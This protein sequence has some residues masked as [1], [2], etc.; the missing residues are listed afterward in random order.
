MSRA[1]LRARLLRYLE[2]QGF[3]NKDPLEDKDQIRK[4]HRAAVL[5]QREKARKHLKRYEPR[6]LG[7]IA[8]G[9]DLDVEKIKPVLIPVSRRS[10]EERLFRYAR[11]HW[12]IPISSGYGRRLRFLVWDDHH[13][14]LMG[15]IGLSDPVYSLAPRDRWVGWDKD[16]KKRRL[17]NVMDAFVL[18]ATPPYSHVLGGKLVAL[19]VWSREVSRAFSE[20]YAQRRSTIRG[21]PVGQLALITTTSALGR[22]SLYNRLKFKGQTIFHPVGFTRGTG[23]LPFL[24][25]FY[26]E[27]FQLV[28][29]QAQPT[30][31]HLSWGKGYRNRRE[32][33][34][35][36]LKLL[37][38]P[39]DMR[40][41]GVKREVYV[42][43]LG[44]LAKEFLQ[45]RI[46]GFCPENA[47]FEELATYALERWVWPRARRDERY[48]AFEPE[49]WHLWSS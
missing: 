39:F 25:G 13:G 21:E 9:R 27:L 22:S 24:N 49:D 44:T 41:H 42:V 10:E 3:F 1:E 26:D 15:L 14:K 48:K 37:Q 6:L 16:T 46:E 36:A 38:L 23:D 12:S 19:G 11:L 47:S 28:Q 31:K 40:H 17:K 35:K 29:K 45:G 18:G 4:L 34:T 2:E 5:Y 7:Y 20:R 33:I 32:V 30:A 8:R 43:P